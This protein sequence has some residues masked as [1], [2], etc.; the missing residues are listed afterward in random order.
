MLL[1]FILIFFY[2]LYFTVCISYWCNYHYSALLCTGQLLVHAVALLSFVIP[3][4]FMLFC[5]ISL[6]YVDGINK[7]MMMMMMTAN[8][9]ALQQIFSTENITNLP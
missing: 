9:Y 7:V 8:V 2:I 4:V 5:L 6:H 1:V 3:S